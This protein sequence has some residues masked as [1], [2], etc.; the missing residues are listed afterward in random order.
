MHVDGLRCV[1]A[2]CTNHQR[3]CSVL[4]AERPTMSTA[5]RAP[6]GS[7]VTRIHVATPCFL[8]TLNNTTMHA[9]IAR[10]NV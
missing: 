7:T 5:P 4:H 2:N 1:G 10:T 3:A 6:E 9:N 8:K